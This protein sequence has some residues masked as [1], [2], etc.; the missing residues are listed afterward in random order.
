MHAITDNLPYL[1]RAAVNTLWLSA[2]SIAISVTLG[3]LIGVAAAFRVRVV[4]IL[5]QLCVIVVR[6]VPLLV[7]LYGMYYGLPSLGWRIDADGTAIVGLSLYFT[8]FVSEV[9]RGAVLAV[10]REQVNAAK[11]IG[12]SFWQRVWLVILPQASRSALP[13]L[14]NLGVILVKGTSYASVISVWE[15]AS[16]STEIAQQTIAPFQVYGFSLLLYFVICFL[17][18]QAGRSAEAKLHYKV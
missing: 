15:L 11:S 6:G 9:V 14:I 12:L 10:P 1:L 3:T 17:L 2:V 8:F 7:I 18:T 5:N 4:A 13:P 16:A